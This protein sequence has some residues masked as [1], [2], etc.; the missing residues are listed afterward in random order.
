MEYDPEHSS[1]FLNNQ[2]LTKHTG[3]STAD[4]A[5][6]KQFN[7][8]NVKLPSMP[9]IS[10]TNRDY[11][12][13]R[14]VCTMFWV[15]ERAKIRDRLMN[16]IIA[17]FINS[18]DETLKQWCEWMVNYVMQIELNDLP[19]VDRFL[20]RAIL[21]G[22]IKD[23]CVAI[24]VKPWDNTEWYCGIDPRLVEHAPP[25][26]PIQSQPLPRLH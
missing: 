18:K 3:V 26:S 2:I 11:T 23:I 25:L 19:K 1:F 9:G 5:I 22:S 10:M 7:H 12:A 24:P 4:N 16:T 17:R 15:V 21:D 14:N 6:M 20:Q 13:F 8:L